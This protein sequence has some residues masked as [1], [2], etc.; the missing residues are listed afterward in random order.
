MATVVPEG[1]HSSGCLQGTE[2]CCLTW[3]QLN[4]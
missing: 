2:S 3:L 1:V 4:R